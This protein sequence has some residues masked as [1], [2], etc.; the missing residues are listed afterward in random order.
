ML[1]SELKAKEFLP[2]IKIND[3]RCQG[4][5][6]TEHF[7]PE[8]KPKVRLIFHIKSIQAPKQKKSPS[9]LV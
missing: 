1:L 3:K 8:A 4:K 2:I 6:E 5:Y 9:I 7:L